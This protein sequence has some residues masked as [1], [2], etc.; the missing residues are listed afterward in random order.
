MVMEE[1]M[2]KYEDGETVA[3]GERTG[4]WAI[5]AFRV[6]ELERDIYPEEYRYD[7]IADD[8]RGN[9]EESD[10]FFDSIAEAKADLGV[11]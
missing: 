4:V 5:R 7:W 8:A 9:Y 1:I 6:P 2:P 3:E 10:S 11:I